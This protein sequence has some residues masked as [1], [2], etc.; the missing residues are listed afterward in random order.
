MARRPAFK[1]ALFLLRAMRAMGKWQ[2]R[3]DRPF[4]LGATNTR[5][6]TVLLIG[7]PCSERGMVRRNEFGAVFREAADNI[8]TKYKHDGFEAS[9]IEIDY[10]DRNRFI[11]SLHLTMRQQQAA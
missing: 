11:E 9:I 4:V 8:E 2:G 3:A 10:E 6:H 1:R 7:V 5:R